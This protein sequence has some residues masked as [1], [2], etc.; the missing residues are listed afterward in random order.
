MEQVLRKIILKEHFKSVLYVSLIMLIGSLHSNI[1]S[2]DCNPWDKIRS[3]QWNEG[4][5]TNGDAIVV[6]E[7][8]SFSELF[9]LDSSNIIENVGFIIHSSGDL[10]IDEPINISNC[11]FTFTDLTA[12]VGI[13]QDVENVQI[14]NC[15]FQGGTNTMWKGI[16]VSAGAKN[17]N[18]KNNQINDAII[19]VYVMG[20]KTTVIIESNRFNRNLYGINIGAQSKNV[21]KNEA[22]INR[23]YFNC[24]S[25]LK[26]NEKQPDSP[27][28]RK[29]KKQSRA[30]I[31]IQNCD[32]VSRNNF[33]GFPQCN[34]SYIKN[35]YNGIVIQNGHLDIANY[36]FENIRRDESDYYGDWNEG[37]AIAVNILLKDLFDYHDEPKLSNIRV[38]GFQTAGNYAPSFPTMKNVDRGLNS[39]GGS[40]EISKLNIQEAAYG[41][42]S[43]DGLVSSKISYNVMTDIGTRGIELYDYNIGGISIVYNDITTKISDAADAV[44]IE[45]AEM[46]YVSSPLEIER[47]QIENNIIEINKGN[48]G[49]W[50]FGIYGA[51]LRYNKIY[52]ENSMNNYDSGIQLVGGARNRFYVNAVVGNL[53]YTNTNFPGIRMIGS[54]GTDYVCNYTWDVPVGLEIYGDCENTSI[55]NFEFDGYNTAI[56][57]RQGSVTG[58]Q[59]YKNNTWKEVPSQLKYRVVDENTIN[60]DGITK[61]KIYD[62]DMGTPQ[63]PNPCDPIIIA[64]YQ[65]FGNYNECV[66]LPFPLMPDT[67]LTKLDSLITEDGANTSSYTSDQ[68]W[69]QD[70][71]LFSKIKDY[72]ISHYSNTTFSDFYSEC[73]NNEISEYYKVDSLL[74][75]VRSFNQVQTLNDSINAIGIYMADIAASDSLYFNGQLTFSDYMEIR[76]ITH[77]KMRFASIQ[78]DM[79]LNSFTVQKN[80]QLQQEVLPLINGLSTPTTAAENYKQALKMEV[81]LHL[82]ELSSTDSLMILSAAQNPCLEKEQNGILRLQT[83]AV[84]LGENPTIGI[85]CGASHRSVEVLKNDIWKVYPNPVSSGIISIESEKTASGKIQITNLQGMSVYE[86][87]F[88]DEHKFSLYLTDRLSAGVYFLTIESNQGSVTEKIILQ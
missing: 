73:M 37:N 24:T 64:D 86:Y 3:I 28:S 9:N 68:Q 61:Y 62:N 45:I 36:I 84:L 87:E 35:H 14:K 42:K 39:I 10:V 15:R 51:E 52:L 79:L 85:N 40:L 18:F 11:L 76:K 50:L 44:G 17:V 80:Q 1:L 31:I 30:A 46:Y 34:F 75:E 88:Y 81:L 38:K 67:E 13:L 43:F 8:V 5:E 23:N 25:P 72:N 70:F 57:H 22:V 58:D 54:P 83:L 78:G 2:Q 19:G 21:Y 47:T 56:I 16:Y 49:M 27:S 55:A 48:S 63:D 71:Y 60:M 59:I 32:L 69:Q 4:W 6:N 77:E 53:G 26:E 29:T 66:T 82:G 33:E 41:I 20:E 12:K 65:G 7:R 74:K